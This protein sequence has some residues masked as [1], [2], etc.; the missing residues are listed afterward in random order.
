M[1]R[2]A[3]ACSLEDSTGFPLV[4]G[5]TALGDSFIAQPLKSILRYGTH[6]RET[7]SCQSHV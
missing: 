7:G 2:D 5:I 6:I 1:I 3:Q 4:Y